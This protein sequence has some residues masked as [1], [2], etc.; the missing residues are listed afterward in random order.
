MWPWRLKRRVEA[1]RPCSGVLYG[2]QRLRIDARGLEPKR[3]VEHVIAGHSMAER[4]EQSMLPYVFYRKVHH[5]EG[6]GS[7]EGSPDI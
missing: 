6:R 1:I 2:Q 7:N 5:D 3:A 4:F